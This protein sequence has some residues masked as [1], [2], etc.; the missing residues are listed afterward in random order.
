[1]ASSLENIFLFVLFVM[2]FMRMRR[3]R[4][5]ADSRFILFLLSYFTLVLLLLGFSCPVIGSLMRFKSPV[6]V[7]VPIAFLMVSRLFVFSK[8]A[9]DFIDSGTQS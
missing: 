5:L 3:N 8:P 1:L 9:K 7:F 6:L 4:P 2:T